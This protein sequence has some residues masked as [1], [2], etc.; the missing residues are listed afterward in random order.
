MSRP[1]KVVTSLCKTKVLL[2]SSQPSL[3]LSLALSIKAGRRA[4]RT[5]GLLFNED[6]V[7]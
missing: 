6:L 7:F 2:F 4:G 3:S 5:P 1:L